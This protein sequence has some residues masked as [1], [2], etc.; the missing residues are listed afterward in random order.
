[1]C[2][3]RHWRCPGRQN[4]GCPS[5]VTGME[6]LGCAQAADEL[7]PDKDCYERYEY[8]NADKFICDLCKAQQHRGEQRQQLLRARNRE[9][10]ERYE[11]HESANNIYQVMYEEREEEARYG[12]IRRELAEERRLDRLE[13]R[14][15]EAREQRQPGIQKLREEERQRAAIRHSGPRRRGHERHEARSRM[16]AAAHEKL[17]EERRGKGH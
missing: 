13:R 2:A 1:M 7:C 4:A 14:Q 9:R 11:R 3:F 8:P 5:N 12:K 17:I 16:N 10:R 15:E 6:Y